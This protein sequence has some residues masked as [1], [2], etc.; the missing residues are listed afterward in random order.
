M[1][2]TQLPHQQE[3][4]NSTASAQLS[5][6]ARIDQ[7]HGQHP[8][9]K[10]SQQQESINSTASAQLPQNNVLQCTI[11]QCTQPELA[12]HTAA[13][14]RQSFEGRCTVPTR[15]ILETLLG[16]S[17]ARNGRCPQPRRRQYLWAILQ[18]HGSWAAAR[19]KDNARESSSVP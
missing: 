4:I 3:S 15:N 6:Q 8:A 1:A 16:R 17:R 7:Q 12:L 9:V 2:S 14:E 5:Y 10:M 13:L 19:V 11:L 18:Q